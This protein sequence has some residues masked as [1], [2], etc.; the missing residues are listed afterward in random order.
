IKNRYEMLVY[1]KLRK[2]IGNSNIFIPDSTEYCSLENDLK[3]KKEF[4]ENVEQICNDGF[5]CISGS[6]RSSIFHRA[7]F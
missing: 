3:D 4:E 7:H 5:F 1:R 2:M 6:N